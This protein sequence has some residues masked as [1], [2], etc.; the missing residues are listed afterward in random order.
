MTE[1]SPELA[2]RRSQLRAEIRRHQTSAYNGLMM[3]G[4][5]AMFTCLVFLGMAATTIVGISAAA[6]FV[7]LGILRIVRSMRTISRSHA[8]LESIERKPLPAARI[9]E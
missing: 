1:D 3:V 6:V 2:H 8:E 7:P 9:V 4:T 5:G